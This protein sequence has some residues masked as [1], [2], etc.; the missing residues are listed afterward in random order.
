MKEETPV[1]M[2][3]LYVAAIIGTPIYIIFMHFTPVHA[4]IVSGGVPPLISHAVALLLLLSV[5][6]FIAG[7]IGLCAMVVGVIGM[8][9]L[10]SLGGK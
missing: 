9:I 1:F 8:I 3:L 6:E 7:I 2:M 4:W 5:G 10:E